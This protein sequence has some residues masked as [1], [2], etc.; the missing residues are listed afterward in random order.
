M[1]TIGMCVSVMV[2]KE[3][4]D[5]RKFLKHSGAVG[6]LAA[7]GLAGC[8]EQDDGGDGGDGDGDDDSTP[9]LGGEDQDF[10]GSITFGFIN[11]VTGPVGESHEYVEAAV[12]LAVEEINDD[13]GVEVESEN[14]RLEYQLY[15]S[16]CQADT[17]VSAFE[18]LIEQDEVPIVL[19]DYCSHVT[20]AM[21]EV[22]GQEEIPLLTAISVNPD[23]TDPEHTNPYMFRNKETSQMRAEAV[24]LHVADTLEFESVGMLAV[25]DDYGRGS[26]EEFS[27]LFEDRG[28]NVKTEEFYEQ[29]QQDFTSELTS[30]KQADVDALYL[31]SRAISTCVGPIEQAAQVGIENI[32]AS[33]GCAQDQVGAQ[34]GD[35][36]NGVYVVSAFEPTDEPEHVAQ[37]VE[38]FNEKAL[39]DFGRDLMPNFLAS[40]SYD[41]VYAIADSIERANA[42]EPG[43][44][45]DAMAETSLGELTYS[46]P[47]FLLEFDENGQAEVVPGLAQ[48]NEDGTRDIIYRPGGD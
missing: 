32:F 46:Y 15:D 6:A 7:L 19:G 25:N 21:M 23:I 8:S 35:A 45:R 48:F 11:P 12:A 24:A 9:G 36:A 16:Q 13:G 37:F 22:A 18:R 47:D 10:A 27:A 38:D 40:P 3:R 43:P 39:N 33:T 42:A 26:V 41:A 14:Y 34:A 5:R 29:E 44:I 4:V 30:I 28:V 20:L 17:G 31:V 2:E 1:V